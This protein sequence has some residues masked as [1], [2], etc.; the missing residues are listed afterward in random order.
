MMTASTAMKVTKSLGALSLVFA[1][2]A[3][4]GGGSDNEAG[5]APS[6]AGT[7]DVKMSRTTDTCN[8][9]LAKSVALV[10]SVSQDGRA[11]TLL[12]N[13]VT[14]RGTVD[15]DN[16]GFSTS[17]QQTSQGV[18]TTTSTVYRATET[19]GLFSA[20]LAIVAS[21]SGGSCKVVYDGSAKLRS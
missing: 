20:G 12:S 3:C 7:Y 6:F 15:A 1:L 11:I 4:G 8:L 10:H 21:G 2:G 18:V 13:K 5:P 14:L 16:G 17:Y 19:P 9:G